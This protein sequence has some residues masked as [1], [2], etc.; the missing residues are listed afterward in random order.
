MP[1]VGWD[2]GTVGRCGIGAELLDGHLVYTV[3]RN[4]NSKGLLTQAYDG[5]RARIS[6]AA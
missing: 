3:S 6:T 5:T 4:S 1:G 2:V